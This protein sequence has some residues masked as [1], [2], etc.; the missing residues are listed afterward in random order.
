MAN[1]IFRITYSTAYTSVQTAR[2]ENRYVF[3]FCMD[4][5]LYRLFD[6]IIIVILRHYCKVETLISNFCFAE[7]IVMTVYHSN[8]LFSNYIVTD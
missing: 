6:R 7:R 1:T 5:N 4:Y 2:I 8:C 3:T